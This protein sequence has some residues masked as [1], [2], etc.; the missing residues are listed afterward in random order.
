[1]DIDGV[2]C[3]RWLIKKVREVDEEWERKS[4]GTWTVSRLVG[5]FVGRLV[6]WLVAVFLSKLVGRLFG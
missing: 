3:S 1:M 4:D 5:M 6:V 2:D